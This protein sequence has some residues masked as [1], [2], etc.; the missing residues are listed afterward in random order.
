MAFQAT[1]NDF[2]TVGSIILGRPIDPEVPFHL[3][4]FK[5]HFGESPFVVAEVWNRCVR[6]FM[7]DP[8]KTEKKHFLWAFYLKYTYG[9]EEVMASFL[10]CTPKT[11]RK[12]AWPLVKAISDCPGIVSRLCTGVAF[13]W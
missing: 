11:L 13:I 3:R 7:F 4:T 5:A 10:R 12:H 6:A 2:A 8:R 1:E 9:T